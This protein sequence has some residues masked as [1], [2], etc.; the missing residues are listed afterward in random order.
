[1]ISSNSNFNKEVPHGSLKTTQLKR[2][3]ALPTLALLPI[4]DRP[5]DSDA[6]PEGWCGE[7]SIQM[8]MSYY[9][10]KIPQKVI[11]AAENSAHPELYADE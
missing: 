8:G 6:P 11:Y 1:M 5:E 4:P 3:I 9:H 7:T 2:P 10:I